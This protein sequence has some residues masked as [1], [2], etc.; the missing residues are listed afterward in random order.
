MISSEKQFVRGHRRSVTITHENYST[1]C[2][3]RGNFILNQNKEI[4][5][6][7]VLNDMIKFAEDS[8]FSYE[9]QKVNPVK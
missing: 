7:T 9:I 8:G 1:I 4:D 5:F 3:H 2:K 6:T